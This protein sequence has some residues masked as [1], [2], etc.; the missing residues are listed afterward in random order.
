MSSASRYSRQVR[1]RFSSVVTH[2]V[3]RKILI[4]HTQAN[5]RPNFRAIQFR[6]SPV[7]AW[8]FGITRWRTISPRIGDAIVIQLEAAH[9]TIHLLKRRAVELD[10]VVHLRGAHRLAV[11]GVFRVGQVDVDDAIEQLEG[12]QSARSPRSCRPSGCATL[13]RGDHQRLEDL[14]DE[15]GGRHEV[16]VV[17]ALASGARAS[18]PPAAPARRGCRGPSD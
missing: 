4:H 17:R 18:S 6:T 5:I 13:V 16:D 2:L 1:R 12:V 9:L 7:P 14:R 8:W 15:V 11:V 10:V 3:C